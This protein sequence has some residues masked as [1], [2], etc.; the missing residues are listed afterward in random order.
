MEP[1][2]GTAVSLDPT[3]AVPVISGAGAVSVPAATG[4]VGALVAKVEPTF[5]VP[6]IVRALW[7]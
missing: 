4:A 2:P 1:R 7:L 3:L 6:A 5:A